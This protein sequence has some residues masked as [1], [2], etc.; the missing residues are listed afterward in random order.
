MSKRFTLIKQVFLVLV[1]IL[2]TGQFSLSNPAIETPVAAQNS[3]NQDSARSNLR[4]RDYTFGY[5][6]N[7]MR[8]Y[9]G[10][11]SAD[12]LC[13]ESGHY[14]MALDMA[15]LDKPKFGF[16]DTDRLIQMH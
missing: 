6:Q 14:G 11:P 10:D 13:I 4:I 5:W 2:T 7:G 15:Q 1:T 9:K 16:F 12:V 8:K 3:T